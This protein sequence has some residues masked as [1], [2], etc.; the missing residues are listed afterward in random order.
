MYFDE[1]HI[2]VKAYDQDQ[3]DNEFIGVGKIEIKGLRVPGGAL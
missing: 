2:T 3:T 1:T